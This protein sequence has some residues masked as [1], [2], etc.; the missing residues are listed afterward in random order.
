VEVP[1]QAAIIQPSFA[2]SLSNR[3]ALHGASRRTQGE[4]RPGR[5]HRSAP[6][7]TTR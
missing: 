1:E 5:Q 7:A 4:W 2:V 6:L 3:T